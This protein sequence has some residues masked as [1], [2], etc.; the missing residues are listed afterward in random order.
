MYNPNWEGYQEEGDLLEPEYYPDPAVFRNSL[1]EGIKDEEELLRNLSSNKNTI[2]VLA[3]YLKIMRKHL[4]KTVVKRPKASKPRQSN[5]MFH[6]KTVQEYTFDINLNLRDKTEMIVSMLETAYVLKA[7][8]RA[9]CV[10]SYVVNRSRDKLYQLAC[11]VESSAS[12]L[13]WKIEPG[14]TMAAFAAHSKKHVVTDNVNTD[15]RFP[16]GL[17]LP[18]SLLK[19]A[20]CVPIKTPDS[21]VVAVYEL[22]R[23]A[24][25]TP[26]NNYDVQIVLTLTG[27][28]G[29]AILQNSL[30]SN[31]A[32]KEELTNYLLQLTKHYHSGN[33]NMD[34]TL[35]DAV[36][37]AREAIGAEK[38]SIYVVELPSKEGM[39][40]THEYDQG[41]DD[42][43]VIF[44]RRV[45]KHV[46]DDGT[47]FGRV[48][49]HREIINETHNNNNMN[50]DNIRSVLTV[51]VLHNEDVLGALKFT[52]KKGTA[53]FDATDEETAKLFTEFLGINIFH[54]RVSKQLK[55]SDLRSNV[56]QEMLFHHMNPCVHDKQELRIHSTQLPEDFF[57]FSWYPSPDEIPTLV[58]MTVHMFH[59]VLGDSFMVMNNVP[60]FVLTVKK[61]Y[62]ANPYHNF[63][64]GFA[65][66]HA[67]GNI[68][69]RH[70]KIFTGLERKSLMV[71]ALC[72]DVDHRGYNNNF[73]QLTKHHLANLYDSSPL[74]NHHFAV[75]KMILHQCGMFKYLSPSIYNELLTEIYEDII[76][77]DLPLYFQC[78]LELLGVAESKTFT[79]K[80]PKHRRLVKNLMMTACDLSGQTKP[81]HICNKISLDVYEEFF[82]QGDIEKKMGYT[83]LPTMDRDKH[84]M[85]AEN[86][87]QFLSVV[88]LPCVQTVARIFNSLVPLAHETKSLVNQWKEIVANKQKDTWKPQESFV[89]SLD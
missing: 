82:T 54:T 47:N 17:G 65:V 34:K 57:G 12:S 14:T 87:V 58:E 45:K 67:M 86:Q 78:K 77:T 21:K 39:I 51:P 61:C 35:S 32:E 66:A 15:H 81:L 1:D 52:N 22:S 63:V 59:E 11:H 41:V 10:V 70:P 18:G 28:M 50:S 27:W 20:L 25:E 83:P 73:L 55:K 42:D 37:F 49:F 24:F 43:R 40:T 56:L 88:V 72:H 29:V 31:L 62:R 38:C 79:F 36:V 23:D 6:K 2:R 69:K 33:A 5:I 53:S 26:F 30:Y 80:N 9:K 74:E 4:L 3:P 64:H 60:N 48:F 13:S 84:D 75:T 46:T 16:E 44:K 19:Y 68:I 8:L 71:A 7:I 85:F 89:H 76:A